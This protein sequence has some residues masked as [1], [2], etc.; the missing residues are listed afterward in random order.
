MEPTVQ[1]Q[2]NIFYG[3]I[4]ECVDKFAPIKLC[5]VKKIMISFG[6]LTIFEMFYVIEMKLSNMVIMMRTL[7]YEIK[8]IGYENLCI[9]HLLITRLSRSL[10]TEGEAGGEIS[11]QFVA[12]RKLVVII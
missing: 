6:L 10:T 2:A 9:E 11:S 7:G 3:L 12:F 5:K 1:G 8:P 4:Q